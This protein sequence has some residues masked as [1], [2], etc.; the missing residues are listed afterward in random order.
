M[1]SVFFNWCNKEPPYLAPCDGVPY[2]PASLGLLSGCLF[3]L[4]ISYSG[5][6]VAG[7]SA[8]SS[9]PVGKLLFQTQPGI[10]NREVPISCPLHPF[11]Q[12]HKVFLFFCKLILESIWAWVSFQL[13]ARVKW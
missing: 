12:P 6:E 13:V 4:S 5:N 10:Q 7:S 1:Q 11:Q 8:A 9:H 3:F 2:G